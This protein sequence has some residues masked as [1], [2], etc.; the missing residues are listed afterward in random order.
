M[1]KRPYGSIEDIEIEEF[2]QSKISEKWMRRLKIWSSVLVVA[3]ISA[4]I[5]IGISD[6]SLS[7]DTKSDV[8]ALK[9]IFKTFKT[10]GV[11]LKEDKSKLPDDFSL[12]GIKPS[13]YNMSDDTGKLLIY[14]FKSFAELKKILSETNK[15]YR[16]FS[17][18]EIPY[19]AKNA[20]IVFI[21]S[22]IPETQESMESFSKTKSLI[23]NIVF[24]HLNDGK[25]RIYK[26]ESES[27]EGTFTLKYYDHW[28][29]DETGKRLYD[30]Y[31]QDNSVIKYK[32]SDID[33]VGEVTFKYETL[34]GSFESA[35]RT[36]N[37]EGYINAGSGS[38]GPI[39]GENEEI[40]FTIKWGDKEE[41]IVLK[42][43]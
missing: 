28:F 18:E 7:T 22:S 37:K 2:P 4:S 24:K 14:T 42:A 12:N 36:L 9:T 26:G 29:Q 39:P 6:Y 21:P 33:S 17:F 30:S 43:Q 25:E 20:L 10:Q 31:S 13:A 32:L 27:W 23:S 34:H 3:I 35:G 5:V 41:H 16:T 11:S 1:S 38:G 15:F 40:K 19:K 8:L